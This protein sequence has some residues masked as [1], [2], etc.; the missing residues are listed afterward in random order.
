MEKLSIE[1]KIT[2]S[3]ILFLYE[4]YVNIS[5]IVLNIALPWNFCFIL[6]PFYRVF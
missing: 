1:I 5:Y 6:F 3:N 4:L 2:K